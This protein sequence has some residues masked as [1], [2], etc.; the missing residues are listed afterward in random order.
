MSESASVPRPLNQAPAP[1]CNLT[2]TE[3]PGGKPGEASVRKC[4]QCPQPFESS[5]P[6]L[7]PAEGKPLKPRKCAQSTSAGGNAQPQPPLC[8]FLRAQARP[9]HLRS[10]HLV[11]SEGTECACTSVMEQPGV[12]PSLWPELNASNS[13]LQR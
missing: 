1:Q 2:S 7:L 11:V 10:R 3:E 6:T 5:L 12:S 4:W 13:D 9:A 8:P